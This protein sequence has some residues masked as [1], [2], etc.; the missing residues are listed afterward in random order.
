MA[1]EGKTSLAVE[2]PMDPAASKAKNTDGFIDEVERKLT[3]YGFFKRRDVIGRHTYM[4]K[5]AYPVLTVDHQHHAEV[6][7][8]FLKNFNNLYITGRNGLVQYSHI[9]D[10]MRN[11]MTWLE[12]RQL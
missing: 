4:L 10:H 1:P 2:V 6:A 9:H 7:L 12:T 3:G 11:A 8:S 5:N